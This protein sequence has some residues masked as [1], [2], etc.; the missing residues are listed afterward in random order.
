MVSFLVLLDSPKFVVLSSF[1]RTRVLL[2]WLANAPGG[3]E[4]RV[5]LLSNRSVLG[6]NSSPQQNVKA[7]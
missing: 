4:E 1:T 7:G 3:V 5:Y 2:Y 6:N